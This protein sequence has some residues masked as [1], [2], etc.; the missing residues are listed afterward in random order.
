MAEKYNGWANYETW[1]VNLWLTNDSGSYDYWN[2][3][4]TD[5]YKESEADDTFSKEQAA[6]FKLE[7]ELRDSIEEANPLGTEASLYSDLINSALRSVNWL[8]IAKTFITEA[9]EEE[10]KMLTLLF[11]LL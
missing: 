10:K 2:E 1:A 7:E 11:F 9:D 3:R 6:A 5:I 8:E 4:A